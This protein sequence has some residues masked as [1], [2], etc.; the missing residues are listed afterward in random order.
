MSPYS[1][2][3]VIELSFDSQ[4]SYVDPFRQIEFKVEFTQPD[5]SEKSI[6]G[7]WAGAHTWKV[8]FAP[9]QLGEYA[10]QEFLF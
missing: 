6:L 8:R 1:V 5:G 9:D 10:Y 7:F 2:N 4:V 3:H